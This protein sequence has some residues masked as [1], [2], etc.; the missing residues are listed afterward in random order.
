MTRGELTHHISHLLTVE[1]GERY[2]AV[3]G[4]HAPSRSKF[5]PSGDE[6]EQ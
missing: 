1:W 2:H 6:N 5:R 3:M 4:T